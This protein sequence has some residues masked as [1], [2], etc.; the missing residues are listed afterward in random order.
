M[1]K[2]FILLFDVTI[3]KEFKHKTCAKVLII[4]VALL[5]SLFLAGC[6]ASTVLEQSR[7]SISD[8]R[9]MEQLRTSFNQ[10]DGEIRLVLLLSPT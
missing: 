4:T 1:A 3:P 10:D 8:L 2:N 7:G 9:D 6:G 5:A